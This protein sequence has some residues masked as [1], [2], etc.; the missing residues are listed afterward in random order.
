MTRVDFYLVPGEAE[1]QRLLAACRI[2]DKALAQGLRSHLLV[3]EQRQAQALDDLLWTFRDQSFV[4]HAIAPTDPAVWPVTIGLHAPLDPREVLFNLTTALPADP[5]RY[6]RIVEVLNQ[7]P[8][9]RQGGRA[10]YRYY[11][12]QGHTLY[13]HE[14]SS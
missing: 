8:T 4:P 6:Q 14:L 1:Q 7:Q 11:R 13:T 9:I 2:A 12:D 10:R 5:T 3:G